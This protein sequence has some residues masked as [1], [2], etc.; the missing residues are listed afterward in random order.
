MKLKWR[1]AKGVN[2]LKEGRNGF[3]GDIPFQ[4]NESIPVFTDDYGQRWVLQ[5]CIQGTGTPQ[6]PEIW[7]DAEFE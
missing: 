3:S 1:K 4:S 2:F 6:D 5:Y 7:V